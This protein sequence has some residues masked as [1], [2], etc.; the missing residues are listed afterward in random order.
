MPK[1]K[2]TK[3]VLSLKE[4]SFEDYIDKSSISIGKRI[5]GF[6]KNQSKNIIFGSLTIFL[7]IFI[8]YMVTK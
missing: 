4:L 2:S 8:A 1:K 6:F 7:S 5:I 3:K